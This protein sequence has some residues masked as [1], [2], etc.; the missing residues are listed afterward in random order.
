M[1]RLTIDRGRHGGVTTSEH[2]DLTDARRILAD[3]A[4][5]ADCELATIQARPEF[6]SW[7]LIALDNSCTIASATIERIHA[8]HTTE[9]HL[10][11]TAAILDAALAADTGDP[12]VDQ[13][14]H[15]VMRMQFDITTGARSHFRCAS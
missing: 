6:S 11:T 3:Y 2:P 1:H 7:D 12:V 13:Y 10:R 8:D 15:A 9:V 4:E 14:E 5:H